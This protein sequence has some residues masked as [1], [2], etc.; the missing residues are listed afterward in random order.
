MPSGNILFIENPKKI[1]EK[2]KSFCEKEDVILLESRVPA[3]L[4]KQ[5]VMSE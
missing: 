2:I 5:L 1:F 3:E 4:I